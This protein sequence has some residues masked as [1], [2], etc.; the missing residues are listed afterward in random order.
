[1]ALVI[2]EAKP[3]V[4]REVVVKE[5]V[6]PATEE[7]YTLTLTRKQMLFLLI[8]QG[9]TTRKDAVTPFTFEEWR[10]LKAQNRELFEQYRMPLFSGN[11]EY[12]KLCQL[13]ERINT[14]VN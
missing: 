6:E 9:E 2:N 4:Y 8:L 12:T 13:M 14:E 10:N 1:M 3:A 7:T 11:N 5:L